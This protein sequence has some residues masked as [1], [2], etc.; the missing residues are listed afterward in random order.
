MP[1]KTLQRLATAAF[2]GTILGAGGLIYAREVETRWLEVSSVEI[3]LPRLGWEF[4]GYRVVQIGDIHLEDWTKP[5]RLN[6]M[7]D[8]VNA[9]EPDLI[10]VTG[11]FLSYSAD[12]GVPRRLVE[13]LRRLRA[14]DGVAAVMGN[15]DYLTDPDLV[16]RCLREAGVPELRNDVRTLMRGDEALH[17]AGV[18]DVM[19]GE[20]RL[21][22]VLRKLP[23]DGAAVLLAHEP[24]F[25]DVSSATGRFDLQLSGHSHGGQVRLPFYGPVFLPPYAQRYTSGLYEVGEMIQYTNR[26]LGFVDARLRFLC[27]PEITVLTLRALRTTDG[28]SRG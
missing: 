8:L 27:R 4:D 16:W 22:L 12:P 11:D 25:A 5:R 17:F 3:T 19:E 14:R 26:G 20:S 15:H 24:D 7:V 28:W 1:G 18:D 6:R 2:G 9:Q 23:E 13:A 10:S 21:D